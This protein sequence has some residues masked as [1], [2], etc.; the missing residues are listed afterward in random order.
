MKNKKQS[1][2]I[3]AFIGLV[4]VATATFTNAGSKGLEAF[5][6]ILQQ[7]DEFVDYCQYQDI[8]R[9]ERVLPLSLFK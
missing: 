6:T 7:A 5:D 8:A 4:I 9:G 1:I 3:I 2:K